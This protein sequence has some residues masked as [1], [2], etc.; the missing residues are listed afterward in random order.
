MNKAEQ[1]RLARIRRMNGK[2][3]K[4]KPISF[5]HLLAKHS[6][7]GTIEDIEAGRKFWAFQPPRR[8]KRPATKNVDWPQSDIDAF[9]LAKLEAAGLQPAATAK[10]RTLV[11]RLYFD[12]IGLSPSP[13]EVDAFLNDPS[14]NA[15]ESLV[16]RLLESPQFGVHWGRHWLDI[17]RYADSNGSD[18]NATF[19]DA[20]RYRD[21]VVA[22][23]NKDK[24][25]D[26]FVIEQIAGDLLPY[27]SDAERSEQMIATGF[28]MVG[29][30][31]LSERDK[32]KLRMDVID[33]Q[34][35]T[36]GLALTGLT[37]RCAR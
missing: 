15:V 9:V 33:E 31:M 11:R 4:R 2:R 14:P 34:I 26:Q 27:D 37:L 10:R 1:A 16:D 32:E 22:A 23:F 36:L 8:H 21:Y 24:P 17:A 25:Y 5:E 28:L 35:D 6:L 19:H 18:F 20:W 12:L 7:P 3:T 13:E 30:K 29:T